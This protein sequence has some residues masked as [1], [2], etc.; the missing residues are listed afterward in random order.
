MANVVF[1]APF[2][3]ETTLRFIEAVARLPEVRLGVVSQDPAERLPE[4]LR[5]RIDGHFRV[6]DGLSRSELATALEAMAREFGSVDR[7]VGTLEQL[8]VTLGELREQFG[9]PG[10]S[11]SVAR[12]FRDKN[13]MK[14]VLEA[15]GV[16]CARHR[17]VFEESDLRAF[18]E[19]VGFPVVV[20]PL[21][22]A[23]AQGTF[24]L[25]DAESLDEY[26]ASFPLG[27]EHSCMAEEFVVGA[28]RSFD[29]VMLD[30]EILWY[31]VN[32]YLPSPLEV[33]RE[34]WIQWCV[35]SRR[36]LEIPEYDGIRAVAPRALSALGMTH[37]LSHMEWFQR[38]D[39]SVAVSEVGARPPGA[40][41]TSV[42]S[43]AC[44]VDFFHAWA[45]LMVEDRFD[46]PDRRYAVGAAFVRAQGRGR[47]I[48]EI[49]GVE[50]ASR[51]LGDIVVSSALPRIGQTPS[52]GYEGD[53]HVIVRHPETRV[54]EQALAFLVRTL[55]VETSES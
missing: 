54:V 18:A 51:Q 21:A 55:R 26:A 2:F 43:Y 49:H 47:A 17:R 1:V 46:P 14:D 9:L 29:S 22:G 6:G 32:E 41:F 35:L 31:T 3:M 15:A 27:P 39:G 44:D 40:Q 7:L 20:K 38:P 13:L 33:L 24:R 5:A 16:P 10:I 28:E 23:G 52:G 36:D 30:G 48:A 53:G 34:P 25:N 19:E 11:A 12:N 45:R 50:Q 8:Q 42:M 4:G 37:G